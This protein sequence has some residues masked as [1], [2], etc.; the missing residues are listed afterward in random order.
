MLQEQFTDI[1][2]L[3]K[4]SRSKKSC[5]NCKGILIFLIHKY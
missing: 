2:Q 5:M 3:V 1:I 4:Q